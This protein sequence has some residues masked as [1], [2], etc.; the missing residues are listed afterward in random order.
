MFGA[1]CFDAVMSKECYKQ[2]QNNCIEGCENVTFKQKDWQFLAKFLASLSE[3]S[4][5]MCHCSEYPLK[6]GGQMLSMELRW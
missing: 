6:S 4:K 2:C 5:K 1:H 3:N